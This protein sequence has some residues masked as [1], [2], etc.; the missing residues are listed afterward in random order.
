MVT[1]VS[2]LTLKYM[3]GELVS[4]ELEPDNDKSLYDIAMEYVLANNVC[5]GKQVKF[6]HEPS[7]KQIHPMFAK[8]FGKRLD[9]FVYDDEIANDGSIWC[10]LISDMLQQHLCVIDVH[11]YLRRSDHDDQHKDNLILWF[12]LARNHSMR[13]WHFEIFYRDREEREKEYLS[14]WEDSILDCTRIKFVV[15]VDEFF[16]ER[17]HL[18]ITDFAKKRLHGLRQSIRSVKKYV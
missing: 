7:G 18:Q 14:G 13:E 6:L 17:P 9:E 3:T 8:S 1:H 16:E 4:V 11:E 5:I 15:D 2:S 10:V 12:N